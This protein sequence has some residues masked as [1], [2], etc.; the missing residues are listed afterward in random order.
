[1]PQPQDRAVTRCFLGT[2]TYLSK[3]CPHL[4]EVVHPLPDLTH[5]NNKLCATEQRYALS[6][7]ETLA[8]VKHF[9][10]LTN[11]SAENLM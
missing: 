8:T 9:T 6:E 7:K 5:L 2:I 3:F 10:S 11:F 1:M 4:N